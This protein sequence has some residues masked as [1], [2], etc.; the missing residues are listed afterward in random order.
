MQTEPLNLAFLKDQD[1]NKICLNSVLRK[2][3]NSI[4]KHVEISLYLIER[5]LVN[6]KNT[7]LI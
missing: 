7:F 5:Q 2:S 4:T 3:V 1:L 6:F